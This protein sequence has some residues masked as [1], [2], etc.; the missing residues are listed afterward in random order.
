MK[1]LQEIISSLDQQLAY[2]EKAS[3]RASA[4]LMSDSELERMNKYVLVV[5]GDRGV[6]IP[7]V[8]LAEIGPL[9]EVT[10]LPNL[11]RWIKGIVN[12]RGEIVS[13]IDLLEFLS[14]Q[15]DTVVTG[16][17]LAVLRSGKI[18]IGIKVDKITATV[19]R[20]D[21]ELQ[22]GK[23]TGADQNGSVFYATLNNEQHSYDVLDINALLN[24]K[25]LRNYYET[26]I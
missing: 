14:G 20:P 21:S 13:V 12:L 3:E 15:R 10:A 5:L 16:E 8:G 1:T 24:L 25:S 7:I 19:N 6:A 18:K 23:A 2:A 17:R 26:G 22:P 9:P 11:P 4:R